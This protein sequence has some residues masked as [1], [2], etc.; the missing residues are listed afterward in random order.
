MW[1]KFNGKR[2]HVECYQLEAGPR[3][4]HCFDVIFKNPALALSGRWITRPSDGKLLH[5]ECY[6]KLLG[7][8]IDGTLWPGWNDQP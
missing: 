8:G 1:G 3:C 6:L 2:Y 7:L 5:Q 4:S